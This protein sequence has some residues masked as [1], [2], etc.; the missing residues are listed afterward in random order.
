MFIMVFT[1]SGLAVRKGKNPL[2]WGTLTLVAFFLT[3]VLM[4]T[5]YVFITYKGPIT[6][7]HIDDLRVYM[8]RFQRDTLKVLLLAMFGVGG[9]LL[10]RYRLSRYPDKPRRDA[11]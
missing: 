9:A 2:V 4:S 11:A 1:N 6:P 10:V 7:D 8:E 5:A 3:Y